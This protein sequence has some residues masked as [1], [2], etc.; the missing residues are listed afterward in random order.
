M[1][2]DSCRAKLS[3]VRC[4][5]PL[6]TR[7]YETALW[8]SKAERP[9][10]DPQPAHRSVQTR[11]SFVSKRVLNRLKLE[12]LIERLEDSG[13][14]KSGCSCRALRLAG[15]LQRRSSLKRV[16]LINGKI[17]GSVGTDC[18]FE[19][20]PDLTCAVFPCATSVSLNITGAIMSFTSPGIGTAL[21]ARRQSRLSH[22]PEA[23]GNVHLPM[24]THQSDF[25]GTLHRL[26]TRKRSRM[27]LG[28][29]RWRA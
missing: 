15:S 24:T 19:A 18:C 13:E 25:Y 20:K 29:V 16:D 22:R 10:P 17:Q 4:R 5:W 14:G 2:G 23:P 27:T 28:L 26:L 7:A 21:S 6:A 12:W 3:C 9:I 11:T 1:I 8:S